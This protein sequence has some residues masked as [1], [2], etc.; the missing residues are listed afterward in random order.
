MGYDEG[1]ADRM[2]TWTWKTFE[3]HKANVGDLILD[4]HTIAY[5][6]ALDE[7]GTKRPG[8]LSP[9][10]RVELS[11]YNQSFSYTD[12]PGAGYSIPC[13]KDGSLTPKN[14]KTFD[15]VKLQDN[16]IYNG[17]L[18]RTRSF[19]EPGSIKCVCGEEVWL[20][21]IMTN[22]CEKC[23]RDYNIGG[24]LLA[25]RYQWGEET[26]ETLSEIL[27]SDRSING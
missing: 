21:N 16:L 12:E 20:G 1:R 6:T 8:I 26:G 3:A 4:E 7:R 15:Y 5:V 13:F 19:N 2:K 23:G 11:E 17:I 24:Q 22:T 10:I 27:A 18:E 25:P 9:E 14:Q